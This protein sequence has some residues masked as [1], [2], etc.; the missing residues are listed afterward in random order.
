MVESAGGLEVVVVPEGKVWTVVVEAAE[1][2]AGAE[3]EPS[4]SGPPGF[5]RLGVRYP[6]LEALAWQEALELPGS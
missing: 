2:L 4:R 5:S 1:G 6:P 3:G